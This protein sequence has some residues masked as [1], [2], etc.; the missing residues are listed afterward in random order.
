MELLAFALPSLCGAAVAWFATSK[1]IRL[2][3]ILVSVWLSVP[4]G[5][6]SSIGLGFWLKD[7][8]NCHYPLGRDVVECVVFG[9]DITNWVNGLKAGG[10]VVAFYGIP[11]FLLGAILLA[12]VALIHTI[13]AIHR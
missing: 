10:Y 7:L 4:L 9:L 8:G 11:W 13:R 3:V 1:R 6:V 5:L 2:W 12:I